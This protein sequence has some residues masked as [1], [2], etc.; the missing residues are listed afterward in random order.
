M[1][2]LFVDGEEVDRFKTVPEH[3]F[4]SF[5][6]EGR[7]KIVI[8][9]DDRAEWAGNVTVVARFWPGIMPERITR[10]L[11]QWDLDDSETKPPKAYADDE[12][13]EG[14]WQLADFMK[15]LG[16]TFPIDSE[17]EWHGSPY[18]FVI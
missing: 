5:D 6:D 1:Y 15:R 7:P 14:A 11:R 10:Y 4:D 2:L 8:D 13:Q 12:Y 16:L 3:W 9:D 18:E 17:G